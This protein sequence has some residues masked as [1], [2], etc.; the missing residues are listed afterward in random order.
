MNSDARKRGAHL[1]HGGI[2][3]VPPDGAG[4][5]FHLIVGD[6]V[7]KVRRT[8]DDAL[9]EIANAGGALKGWAGRWRCC[10][11]DAHARRSTAAGR[12]NLRWRAAELLE[13][14]VV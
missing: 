7:Q 6:V 14:R 5:V 3:A 10:V 11:T 13:Q 4:A 12:G 8:G 1:L 9:E 2:D